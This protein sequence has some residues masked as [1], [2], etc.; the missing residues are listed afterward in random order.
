VLAGFIG[1]V[2]LPCP[3]CKMLGWVEETEIDCDTSGVW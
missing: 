1:A 2:R 3:R